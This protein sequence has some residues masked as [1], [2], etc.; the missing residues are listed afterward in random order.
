MHILKCFVVG[1]GKHSKMLPASSVVAVSYLERYVASMV[2]S[3][4]G[5]ALGY[6][7]GSWEFCHSG[8][9]IVDELKK[10]GGLSSINIEGQNFFFCLL[11]HIDIIT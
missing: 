2:L 5:D 6:K 3:G 4:V 7:N 9:A 1:L 8:A 11:I 10:M